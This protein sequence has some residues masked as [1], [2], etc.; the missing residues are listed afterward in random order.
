MGH[1]KQPNRL[2]RVSLAEHAALQADHLVR[3]LNDSAA[4]GAERAKAI[5]VFGLCRQLDALRKTAPPF[6]LPQEPPPKFWQYSNKLSAL[7]KAANDALREFRFVPILGGGPGPYWVGWIPSRVRRFTKRQI[8][9]AKE[10]GAIPMPPLEAIKLTLEMT[11]A[12]TLDRIRECVCGRWFFAASGKKMACSDACRFQ[13][14]KQVDPDKFHKE[15]AEY[16]KEYRR[17]PR[18][19]AKKEKR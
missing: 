17:N 19:K 5:S 15:R 14:F 7:L 1:V 18:V 2:L 12:G 11:E 8:K 6:P 3:F 13:K 16:M 4:S 9:R 10:S